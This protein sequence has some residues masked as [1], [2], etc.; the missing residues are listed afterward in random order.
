MRLETDM[1]NSEVFGIRMANV[2]FE[3]D[4]DSLESFSAVTEEAIRG[5]YQHLC[6]KIDVL[7]N[8]RLNAFLKQ[9]FG[10]VD[11]QIMY[12]ITIHNGIVKKNTGI[13]RPY[14]FSDK[15]RILEIAKN[16]YRID[17]FH[18]DPSL[19]DD[20][21]DCYYEK[22]S[23][24][25]CERDGDKVF[26]IDLDGYVLGFTILQYKNKT[27]RAVLAAIDSKYQGNGYYT[28]LMTDVLSYLKCKGFEKLYLGIQLG[29]MPVLKTVSRF[30]GVP[31]YCKYVLHKRL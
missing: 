23:K 13:T 24:N 8:K 30:S 22:W 3:E 31:E 9:E 28:A 10:L 29:N 20:K 18:M 5:Q 11:T 7:D 27:A 6:A 17:R 26:V 1:F 2:L 12:E 25:L 14:D 16:A 15:E 21:C 19:P 4:S